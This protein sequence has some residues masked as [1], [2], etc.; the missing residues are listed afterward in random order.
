MNTDAPAAGAAAAA[1]AAAST[2]AKLATT[3]PAPIFRLTKKICPQNKTKQNKK[4][5]ENEMKTK[6]KQN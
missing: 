1:P 4:R 3:A 2:A 5:N 6:L